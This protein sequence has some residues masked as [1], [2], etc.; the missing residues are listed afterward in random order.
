MAK[1]KSPIQ[2]EYYK[3][4]KRIQSAI[5]R[6]QK[7]GFIVDLE[8]PPIPKKI[9][10]ASIRR[11]KKITPRIIRE[12]SYAVSQA[13]GEVEEAQIAYNRERIEK[14]KTRNPKKANKRREAE[15][16]SEQ[17]FP[18]KVDIVINNFEEQMLS[19]VM[20][21][22][23]LDEL[24]EMLSNPDFA[25]SVHRKKIVQLKSRKAIDTLLNL[26]RRLQFGKQG[27]K[28]GMNLINNGDMPKIQRAI[29]MAMYGYS[30]EDVA[31]GLND[32]IAMLTD[33]G[34]LTGQQ[35]RDL[36]QT[37]DYINR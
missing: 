20:P 33:N 32:A 35:F 10:Q 23:I 28:V 4:R 18:N 9:T 30:E 11:L 2:K 22:D 14:A 27:S 3:Q 1:N 7:R 12:K 31:L 24:K 34:K 13:T 19:R 6:E 37:D 25:A 21:S 17:F 15:K 29:E 16:F 26:I 8:L 5:K 36:A